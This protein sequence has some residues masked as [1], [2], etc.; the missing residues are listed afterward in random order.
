MDSIEGWRSARWG[1]TPEAILH[2]FPNE[3]VTL[4]KPETYDNDQTAYVSIPNLQVEGRDFYA[5]YLFDSERQLAGI[6]LRAKD[7]EDLGVLRQREIF[8]S[9]ERALIRKYGRP[10]TARNDTSI[11][12]PVL[13]NL[14]LTSEWRFKKTT[15]AI[16]LF[17]VEDV[18]S[19]LVISYRPT[20]SP[21]NL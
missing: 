16:T 21:A 5:H 15:I 4:R 11:Q 3:A 7:T 2:A 1:M 9:F 13:E 20:A 18:T 10:T 19:I 6:N 12:N 8:E 17:Y 14:K